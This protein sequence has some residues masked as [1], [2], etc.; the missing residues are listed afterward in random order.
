MRSSDG[1][2]TVVLAELAEA[3][4]EAILEWTAEHFGERQADAYADALLSAI[5]ALE[6]G[7]QTVGVKARRDLAGGI[8]TLH[9]ARGRRRARHLLVFHM[10][11]SE[12][13]TIT[14]LRTL[15][16]SMDIARHLPEE[17]Q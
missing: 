11:G 17:D 10:S 13:R 12:A 16:D 9:A 15:H 7:P 5:D 6:E 1:S 4:L 8:F 2:W 3:D 14:V